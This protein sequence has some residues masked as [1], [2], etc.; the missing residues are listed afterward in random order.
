MLATIEIDENGAGMP[1]PLSEWIISGAPPGPR[2]WQPIEDSRQLS[3]SN[4][5]IRARGLCASRISSNTG[6]S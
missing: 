4:Q 5:V 2:K 6:S 3:P 1:L